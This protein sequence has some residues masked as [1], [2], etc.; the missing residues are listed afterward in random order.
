MRANIAVMTLVLAAFAA[1]AA[2][3]GADD[4]SAYNRRAA[5]TYVALFKSLDRNGD[6]TVTR[7]EA[8]GDLN[9]V[10]YFDDMDINRDGI[11]TME[12]LR[13]YIEMRYDVRI[14]VAAR[15]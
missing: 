2:A 5:E 4:R 13:R 9:F 12:E 15:P 7:A 11:V 10:P 3:A 14:E 6:A 8:G 1:S